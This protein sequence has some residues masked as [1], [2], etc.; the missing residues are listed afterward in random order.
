M[1]YVFTV[2]SYIMLAMALNTFGVQLEHEE[3]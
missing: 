3:R 1:D 2:G